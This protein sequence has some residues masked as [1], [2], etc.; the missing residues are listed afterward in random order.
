MKEKCSYQT[1]GGAARGQTADGEH[2]LVTVRETEDGG[3][4][5]AGLARRDVWL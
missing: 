4:A 2:L 5:R 3:R 1:T